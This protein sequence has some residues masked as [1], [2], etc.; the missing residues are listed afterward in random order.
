MSTIGDNIKKYRIA[1]GFTQKEVAKM[2]GKSKNVVSN[3]EA[4]L[5]KP[6]ADT[7]EMLLDIFGVDANTLL[8]WDDPQQMKD[9][10]ADDVDKL[11]NDPVIKDLVL[12]VQKLSK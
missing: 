10:V 2:V 4:G 8:G 12:S 11:L 1:K 7:I 9:D 5:N 3:W 6:D